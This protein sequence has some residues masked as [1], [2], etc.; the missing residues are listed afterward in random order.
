MSLAKMKDAWPVWTLV[1]AGVVVIALAF[2]QNKTEKDAVTFQDIFS[3]DQMPK[4]S[5]GETAAAP[6]VSDDPVQSPAIVAGSEHNQQQLS[7]AVQLYSFKE[8]ARAD[9]MINKLKAEGIPAYAQI[10]DLGTKGTWYRVRVGSFG[11]PDEAKA[12]LSQLIKDHKDSIIVK[13]RK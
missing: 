3:D 10:S 1:I 11:T 13:D 7:Y 5:T 12:M 2:G 9:T 4:T 8:Q 6:A